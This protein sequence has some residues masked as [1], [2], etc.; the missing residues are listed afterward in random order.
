[1]HLVN[2]G[3][4][5]FLRW[6]LPALTG[7]LFLVVWTAVKHGFD[8]PDYK[9]PTPWRIAQAAWEERA[10][11]GPAVL[12]TMSGAVLG[13]VSAAIAG[14]AIA[15]V[16]AS[17]KWIRTAFYPHVLIVQMIPVIV[18]A[19]L[20]FLWIGSGTQSVALVTFL[21]SFFPVVANTTQGLISTD[22]NLVDLFKMS[23]ASL[24][25]EFFLLR[26]PYALP[27]YL[28]G[29]RIAASLAMIGAITG[30]LF[31]GSAAGGSGGLGFLVVVYFGQVLTPAV[32]AAGFLACLCGFIFVGSVQLLS[33][34]LLRKWHESYEQGDR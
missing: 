5:R 4:S 16:L 33:W 31:L 23:G 10:L 17:S 24:F 32:L 30:E 25:Q 29:L 13:F 9:L 18:L 26:I 19:P 20:F 15:I 1:M 7:L 3:N 11:L 28:T 2:R 27:Y 8:Q 14:A 34:L 6:L 22:R 21:I 12:T